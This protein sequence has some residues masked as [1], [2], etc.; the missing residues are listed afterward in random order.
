MT[1]IGVFTITIINLFW[2]VFQSSVSSVRITRQ[3]ISSSGITGSLAH[4]NQIT[5]GSWYQ[6]AVQQHQ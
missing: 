6:E 2:H 5:T 4:G 3:C 1:K